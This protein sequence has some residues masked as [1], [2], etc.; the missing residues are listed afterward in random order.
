MLNSSTNKSNSFL[1]LIPIYSLSPT[2]FTA[3]PQ[4]YK[5]EKI[6][7]KGSIWGTLHL[8]PTFVR[9]SIHNNGIRPEKETAYAKFGS[10][11]DHFIPKIN[12]K[13]IFS[14]SDLVEVT[15]RSFNLR[16]C[17][18]ELFFSN[19]ETLFFNVFEEK[20]QK[21]I[22]DKLG[23]FNKKTKIIKKRASA[24][25]DSGL[26]ERWAKGELSNFDYL[27][28]IN[29]SAGRTY[30]DLQQYPVFPWV[31]IDFASSKLD[32]K[33]LEKTFRRLDLPVGALNAPRL[34]EFLERYMIMKGQEKDTEVK[35]FM[36]GSHYS[37]NAAVLS[38]MIRLEPVTSL[39]IKL[40]NGKF[41]DADRIFGSVEEVWN[42][43]NSQFTD[44]KELVPEFY[45]GGSIFKNV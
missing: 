40:Q 16:N 29:R 4:S 8:D 3:E 30:N 17:A 39:C 20:I 11:T 13:K 32:F 10:K 28:A 41:D 35:A 15:E 31:L 5:A 22:L 1:N 34:K 24:F 6:T 36:Y 2:K 45:Y 33:N 25:K 27:M 19:G 23:K 43:V 44:V 7:L 9:F 42:N 26:M 12:K 14:L 37:G 38:Y 18:L 21:E